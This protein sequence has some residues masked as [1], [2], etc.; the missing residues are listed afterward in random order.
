M[1]DHTDPAPATVVDED[2]RRARTLPARFYSDPR[3]HEQLVGVFERSWLFAGHAED[4]R[5]PGSLCPRMLLPGFLDEPLLLTRDASDRTHLLSNVCTHRGML[6]AEAP[7]RVKNLRCRYHGR[8]FSLDGRCLGMPEFEEV[9]GFPGEADDLARLP[10]ESWANL[11]FTS[12]DPEAPFEEVLGP[13]ARRLEGFP[14]EEARPA[15]DLARDYTIHANWA[16]YCDN[17]LESFHV[18]FVH[19]GLAQTLDYK[20]LEIELFPFGSL[21]VGA[22]E[23]R[24]EAFEWPES[25]RWYGRNIAALWF[26][27]FPNLMLSFFPWGLSLTLVE[28]LAIDRTRIRYFGYVL[29]PS[30]PHA[31]EAA[32]IDRVER[33]DEEIVEA[34]QVGTKSRLY[35]YGR[36]SPRQEPAVHHFHRL[37]A[38]RLDLTTA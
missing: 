26:H 37:L 18:P 38:A 24:A 2:I 15:P 32:R 12:L 23:S 28:P 10:L 6:V 22:A 33:E 5:T 14:M 7:G 8:R 25:S 30:R 4:V 31:G 3:I 34:V 13:V 35:R 1:I 36:Y 17:Y 16:L 27:I 20:E 29:D 11:L 21:Q 19:P 9:D